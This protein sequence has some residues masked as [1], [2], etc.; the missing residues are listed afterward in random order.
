MINKI[1]VINSSAKAYKNHN[2]N[3]DR[4]IFFDKT[5][6][7]TFSINKKPQKTNLSFGLTTPVFEKAV[8]RL[9]IKLGSAILAFFAAL[10]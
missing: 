8:Q 3:T 4:Q 7:D 5:N 10:I 1:G 2:T 6:T 9:M